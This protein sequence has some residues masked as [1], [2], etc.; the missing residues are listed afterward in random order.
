MEDQMKKQFAAIKEALDRNLD[1]IG[2]LLDQA[3]S[4]S[5]IA[6]TLSGKDQSQVKQQLE[7][8][9]KDILSTVANLIKQTTELFTL[10]N[11]FAETALRN[12]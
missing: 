12:K 9:V 8:K 6:E 11:N 2:I 4:L 3:K 10:Y 5:D 1:T 7:E